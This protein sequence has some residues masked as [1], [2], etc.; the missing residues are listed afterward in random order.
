MSILSFVYDVTYV[1]LIE[2]SGKYKLL[3]EV[4]RRWY[5]R[6]HVNLYQQCM[7]TAGTNCS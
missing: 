3:D 6:H 7:V 1:P 4:F 2:L 5:L